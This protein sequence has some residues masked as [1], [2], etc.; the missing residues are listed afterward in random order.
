MMN[1]WIHG[2]GLEFCSAYVAFLWWLAFYLF[3]QPSSVYFDQNLR[4]IIYENVYTIHSNLC[5]IHFFLFVSHLFSMWYKVQLL[6]FMFGRISRHVM[7]GKSATPWTGPRIEGDLGFVYPHLVDT[8]C[9]Y[10]IQLA[11]IL[12]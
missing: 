3:S 10:E 7:Q 2:S 1:Y 8:I 6:G 5:V 11:S 9:F 12:L 4:D